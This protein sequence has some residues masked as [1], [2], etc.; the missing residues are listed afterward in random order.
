MTGGWFVKRSVWMAVVVALLILLG[1]PLEGRVQAQDALQGLV[2]GVRELDE[3]GPRLQGYYLGYRLG[4]WTP[5]VGYDRLAVRLAMTYEMTPR[6][7]PTQGQT[8]TAAGVAHMPWGGVKYLLRSPAAGIAVPY[9]VAAVGK[10]LLDVSLE[11]SGDV[12]EAERQQVKEV[13][14]QIRDALPSMW[15][16]QGA[17][18]GE[19]F[20]SDALAIAAEAGLRYLTGRLSS[21]S[22][23]DYNADGIEDV[24]IR[25]RTSLASNFTFVSV[26]LTYYF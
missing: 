1:I 8:F 24:T 21:A 12:T 3:Q 9:V 5:L 7:E 23:Q 11:L 19:Y 10:P 25:T 4:G 18:G 16:V 6:G 14:R 22:S 20:F 2:F 13:E 17:V 15:I 26:G